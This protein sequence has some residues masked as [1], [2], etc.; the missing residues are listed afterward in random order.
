MECEKLIRKKAPLDAKLL[1]EET[2]SFSYTAWLCEEKVSDQ[3]SFKS[4]KFFNNPLVLRIWSDQ[5]LNWVSI[6]SD[7]ATLL[8]R[9]L[10]EKAFYCE[11]KY[12]AL[13]VL[14]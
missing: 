2:P 12:I 9:S 6:G 13:L 5:P 3:L 11:I 10:I 1:G 14:V 8:L 4:T 7:F